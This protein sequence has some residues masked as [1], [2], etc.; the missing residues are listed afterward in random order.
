ML[1][2]DKLWNQKAEAAELKD[3]SLG[4][5]GHQE[6]QLQNWGDSQL[7]K[8]LP[9]MLRAQ[10]LIPRTGGKNPS[11]KWAPLVYVCI[12][13]ILYNQ[14]PTFEPVVINRKYFPDLG[15]PPPQIYP[16]SLVAPY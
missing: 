14:A 4:E 12:I 5:R 6:A 7:A 1:N 8:C 15:S 11:R 9:S 16:S 2:A 10:R 3:V 13:I